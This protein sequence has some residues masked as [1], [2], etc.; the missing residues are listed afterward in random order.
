MWE[1]EKD[2]LLNIKLVEYE[3]R[4]NLLNEIIEATTYKKGE[5]KKEVYKLPMPSNK[6]F[7][8]DKNLNAQIY[9]ALMLE[10]NWGGKFLNDSTRYLYN[11]KFAEIIKQASSDTKISMQ[12]I[13]KH[14]T[15]LKKCDMKAIELCKLNNGELV[16]FLN[17]GKFKEEDGVVKFGE[18]VTITNVALR[19][20]V[21]V[22]NNNVIKIYLYLLYRCYNGSVTIGQKEICE[23]IGISY[24]SRVIV[25]DAVNV[26]NEL[27]FIN[28]DTEHKAI[29]L[30][31][32]NGLDYEQPIP[33]KIY[34]LSDEYFKLDKKY[35]KKKLSE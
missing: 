17:Y 4:K 3:R 20:L 33:Q 35:M 16:Y 21:N 6:E 2:T 32:S 34:S 26:L 24:A 25:T 9:G 28:V 7:L 13:K 12:T 8:Q 27:G 11:D 22:T 14:I 31:N 30:T 19:I 18:Y 15:R 5:I 1:K 23:A 29:M 10:S